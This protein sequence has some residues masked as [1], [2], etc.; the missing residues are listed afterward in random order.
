VLAA[1]AK[2]PSIDG[3]IPMVYSLPLQK[4]DGLLDHLLGRLHGRSVHLIGARR[5]HQIGHLQYRIDVGIG[6]K[7]VGVGVRIR[8]RKC[9]RTGPTQLVGDRVGRATG[10]SAAAA[11]ALPPR[12]KPPVPAA[13][14]VPSSVSIL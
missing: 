4:F 9:A 14:V 3:E 10:A 5:A 7:T 1:P 6:D 2:L 11:A 12:P 13:F 8:I